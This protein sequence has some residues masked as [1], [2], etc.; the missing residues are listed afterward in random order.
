MCNTHIQCSTGNVSHAFNSL[1]NRTGRLT[2]QILY[3]FYHYLLPCVGLFDHCSFIGRMFSR[4]CLRFV[5]LPIKS[6]ENAFPTL[7]CSSQ[8]TTIYIVHYIL[9]MVHATEKMKSPSSLKKYK[10]PVFEIKNK[11]TAQPDSEL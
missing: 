4:V 9:K 11:K 5:L 6:P 10:S 2:K 7:T 1:L 8:G 3:T